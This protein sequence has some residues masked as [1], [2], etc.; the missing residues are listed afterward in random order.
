MMENYQAW[1]R[2]L[3]QRP[4]DASARWCRDN[5][6]LHIRS[7]TGIKA[8]VEQARQNWLQRRQVVPLRAQKVRERELIG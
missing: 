6:L 1:D 3:R 7:R 5:C 2:A 4:D 8:V